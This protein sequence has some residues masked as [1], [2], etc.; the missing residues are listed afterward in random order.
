M[1][2]DTKADYGTIS[3]TLHWVVSITI[4]SLLAAGFIM[5]NL[6]K[7]PL[8][9]QIYDMHK[10]LGITILAIAVIR[11]IWRI[12]HVKPPL[13][14]NYPK[15]QRI[16]SAAVHGLLYLITIVMPLSGWVMSMAADHI[17]SWFG[18]FKLRLPIA[19]SK[20]LAKIASNSHEIIA[21]VLI[22]CLILHIGA[23]IKDKRVLNRML[24]KK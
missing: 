17:P 23:A 6:D 5:I 18:L 22:A 20:P 3:K 21:W 12:T 2:P 10:A 13:P 15:W 8:K 4:I 1:N 24:P 7:S 14:E 16:A 9:W 11:I 19:P